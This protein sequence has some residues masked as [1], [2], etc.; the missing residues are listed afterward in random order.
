MNLADLEILALDC[1]ATGANP[2]KGHLLEIGWIQTCAAA[3]VKPETLTASAYQIALPVDVDIPPAVQRI[4]GITRT[5]S[6][7]ALPAADVWHKLIQAANGTA[8]ANQIE[9]CPVIIH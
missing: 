7:R 4:T 5:D 9:Q 2:Q 8:V 3:A 6:A 1:Q